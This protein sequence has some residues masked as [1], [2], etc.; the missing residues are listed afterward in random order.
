CQIEFDEGRILL[1]VSY[2][3]IFL[4]GL[5]LNGA[6]LWS[7]CGRTRHWRTCLLSSSAI[8]VFFFVNLHCSMMFLTCI[9]MH[10][11]IGVCFPIATVRPRT[12]KLA[13]FAS[14][15]VWVL[16]TAEILLTLV[17]ARTGVINNITVCFEMTTATQFKVYFPYGL[18]L[19]IVGFLIPFITV[20]ICYCSMIK[21]LHCRAADSIS[22]A[23]TA[24][25]RN[26]S[27]YILLVVCLMFVVCFLPYHFVRTV[28]LFV[29]VSM[30]GDCHL[31]NAVMISYNVWKPAVSFNC[32]ANPFLYFW[33]SG[34]YNK[35]WVWLRRKKKRVQPTVLINCFIILNIKIFGNIQLV[36]KKCLTC[37]TC[38]LHAAI[39]T[40]V[41]VGFK[42]QMWP[43]VILNT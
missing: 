11:F 5:S 19:A 33:G 15:L 1:S 24:C 8:Q 12:K 14:G 4:V 32:C 27:L 20:V 23:R 18:F 43:E 10:H 9:S 26:K 40:R 29:R 21:V 16:A 41:K 6:L 3:L 39:L 13:F 25:M 38:F 7:V 42:K 17:F 31:L 2:S 36:I 28:Y 37:E 35:L 30:P 22:T 34:G